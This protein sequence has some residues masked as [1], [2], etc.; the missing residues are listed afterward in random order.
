M[1]VGKKSRSI[2][3]TTRVS[4]T[5]RE[6]SDMLVIAKKIVRYLRTLLL[7][8]LK[9]TKK[10]LCWNNSLSLEFP[11]IGKQFLV[12]S[13]EYECLIE[14][15][16]LVEDF[17]EFESKRLFIDPDLARKMDPCTNVRFS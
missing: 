15:I 2:S 11:R 7:T 1:S 3:Q 10:V 6:D 13:C 14:K 8:L 17:I 9:T 16:D 5:R 12:G 4:S